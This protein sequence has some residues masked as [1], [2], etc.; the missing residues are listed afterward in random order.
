VSDEV[1]APGEQSPDEW[2]PAAQLSRVRRREHVLV[3]I[4]RA[5]QSWPE[6]LQVIASA[7]DAT[8]A[9]RLLCLRFEF[10]DGQAMAVLDL[11]LRRVSQLER[12]RIGQELAQLREEIDRLTG[13]Q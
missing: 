11:Q 6:F 10:D 8:D 13:E 4:A 7:T 12:E 1:P 9:Q 3:A 2:S 5:Q